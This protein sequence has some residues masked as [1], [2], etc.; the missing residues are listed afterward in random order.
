MTVPEHVAIIMD[1]NSRWA[2]RRRLPRAAGHR[3]GVR[4][5]RR[6]A[7]ACE[8]L[9]VRVVTLYAFSTENWSRPRDEVDHLM[10]LFHETLDREVD[11]IHK[12]GIR[13]RVS[14]RVGELE[15]RLQEKIQ[16]AEALTAGNTRGVI[17]LALNYGGR[18]EIVDACRD[19]I[20]RGVSAEELD[21][22]TFAAALYTRG[23]PDPDLLIRTA[24]ESR[25]SNFLLWQ[26]A[27]AE[28]HVT[29][30]LWPDFGEKNL[31]EAILDYSG[32]VRRFG[33]RDRGGTR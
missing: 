20:R 31:V 9:G 25:I 1:G 28:I 13:L 6:V 33:G 16:R 27:Y 5:I 8:R 14:G 18:A 17:N 19:L 4:A 11:R 10:R 29:D 21:E 30:T 7:E 3:E 2:E 23:L 32:R 22:A 15:P 24:G 26:A 12:R